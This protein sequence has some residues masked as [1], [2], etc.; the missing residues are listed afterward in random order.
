M[1]KQI[2]ANY[3]S[4]LFVW[5]C[6]FLAF[7]LFLSLNFIF[8]VLLLASFSDFTN[9]VDSND[10]LNQELEDVIYGYVFVMFLV[11]MFLIT[12]IRFINKNCFC[13]LRDL[14]LLG[15]FLLAAFLLI[16]YFPSCV[17]LWAMFY[18]MKC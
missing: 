3:S 13:W 2:N 12:N 9:L 15:K 4:A 6:F 5:L 8:L 18:C 17:Y 16:I 1:K 10:I 14:P 11:Y 7:P